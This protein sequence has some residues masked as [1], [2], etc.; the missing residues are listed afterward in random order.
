MRKMKRPNGK[1]ITILFLS[2]LV[3]V[4]CFGSIYEFCFRP[5]S[6]SLHNIAWAEDAQQ[7]RNLWHYVTNRVVFDVKS[8]ADSRRVAFYCEPKRNSVRIYVYG[9]TNLERQD[10][11]LLAIKD[12]QVTNQNMAKL[13]VSFFERENWIEFTNEQAG[14]SGGNRLSEILLRDSWIVL[15]NCQQDLILNLPTTKN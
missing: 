6:A 1:Q 2:I 5:F 7:S 14:Y 4:A 8:A 15:S 9:L 3:L 12:W 11:I 10:Q 13:Q